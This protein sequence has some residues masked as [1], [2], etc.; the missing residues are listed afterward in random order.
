M[1]FIYS[2]LFI[3]LN[4]STL[5][6]A[7]KP[8][9][10]VGIPT[11]SYTLENGI[12]V[13]KLIAEP[14]ITR[15]CQDEMCKPLLTWGYNGSM[16]GPTIEV[17]EGD[18]VRIEVTNRLPHAT[19]VHWHGIELPNVM[20]GG[21]SFTQPVIK[22]DESYT[23]EF[24]LEQSGT[25]MY[26]SSELP[27][28]QVGLGLAGFFI[29]H[30]KEDPIKVDRDYAL[31]LQMWQIP[32][33]QNIPDAMGMEFNWLTINGK[34]HP[35][36]PH[37][38]AK[39]RE[40]VRIRFG[41][42][43]MM[44]HPIHLHGHT[45]EI[46]ETGSGRNPTSA[47]WRANTFAVSAGETRTIEFKATKWPGPWLLHCHF[48]HHIMNDMHRPPVPGEDRHAMGHGGMFTILEVE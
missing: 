27:A 20:D 46:V 45:F 10:T 33:H 44:E 13:F 32:P 40:N 8:V 41:N 39:R 17:V 23:Y 30:P 36:V 1:K 26:H 25:Y 15:F 35:A 42:L 11:L 43:S 48:L 38:K 5:K 47:H 2:F 37:L 24:T 21:G 3:M 6:A 16:P 22:P 31:M 12:K 19:V 34:V 9:E 14:V 7:Y 29:V 28:I 18:R 4:V